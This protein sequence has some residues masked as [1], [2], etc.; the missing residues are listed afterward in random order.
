[1]FCHDFPFSQV[2]WSQKIKFPRLYFFFESNE[3]CFCNA[4]QIFWKYFFYLLELQQMPRG[5][6]FLTISS[7]LSSLFKKCQRRTKMLYSKIP[8]AFA[9]RTLLNQS[10]STDCHFLL[11][12]CYILLLAQDVSIQLTVNFGE[13][14]LFFLNCCRLLASSFT[15]PQIMARSSPAFT[16]I[17]TQRGVL[18]LQ[19]THTEVQ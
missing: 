6:K 4:K 3:F 7:S 12:T 2:V 5:H 19:H 14:V 15:V 17:R 13:G 1:V 8:S 18:S 10:L 11:P 16:Q 9:F